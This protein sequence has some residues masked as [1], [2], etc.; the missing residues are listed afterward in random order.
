MKRK[1]RVGIRRK[2]SFFSNMLERVAFKDASGFY[3]WC[4]GRTGSFQRSTGS[5]IVGEAK[6][7]LE[8]RWLSSLAWYQTTDQSRYYAW[9]IQN[10]G[11]SLHFRC[12]QT[13]FGRS[14]KLSWKGLSLRK[15]TVRR[16]SSYSNQNWNPSP[17]GK[18]IWVKGN[19]RFN[20]TCNPRTRPT[21]R[22]FE[23][24]VMELKRSKEGEKSKDSIWRGQKP[25]FLS[26]QG[27]GIQ[28]GIEWHPKTKCWEQQRPSSV[29]N[30]A[31]RRPTE[32]K[33]WNGR[34]DH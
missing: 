23:E 10:R 9:S 1:K 6:A 32:H 8:S 33:S 16:R 13:W 19:L 14:V 2:I 29:I 17:V 5:F 11:N 18:R 21:E 7:E 20:P 26:R 27:R 31:K 28:M 34:G 22:I 24:K 12:D 3:T 4:N 25:K 15:E 30:W